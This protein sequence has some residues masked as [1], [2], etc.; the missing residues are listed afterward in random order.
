MRQGLLASYRR[1]NPDG[2][3]VVALIAAQAH[4]PVDRRPIFI[5]AGGRAVREPGLV[6]AVAPDGAIRIGVARKQ[7]SIQVEEGDRALRPDI[8]TAEEVREIARRNAGLDHAAEASIRIADATRKRQ[9]PFAPKRVGDQ[10]AKK[11]AFA[12]RCPVML[13][14][15]DVPAAHAA[16]MAGEGTAQQKAV[17]VE[18]RDRFD[19]LQRLHPLGQQGVHPFDSPRRRAAL[20]DPV[21]DVDQQGVRHLECVFHMLGQRFGEVQRLGLDVCEFLL[22]L[23]PVTPSFEPEDDEAYHDYEGL[24]PPGRGCR[25][26]ASECS[27]DGAS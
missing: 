4:G 17:F 11:P 24:E 13:E 15:R 9:D 16:P 3:D 26:D 10:R 14:K 20:F 23:A 7:R 8:E 25:S 5:G 21:H 27:H 6:G 2:K 18:N 22:P 12:A 19:A 1:E